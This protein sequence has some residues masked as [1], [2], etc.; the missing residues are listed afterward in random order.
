MDFLKLSDINKIDQIES[1]SYYSHNSFNNLVSFK[2]D[3]NGNGLLVYSRNNYNSFESIS[4]KD[5]TKNNYND[6][7]LAEIKDFKVLKETIKST[8]IKDEIQLVKKENNKYSVVGLPIDYY[9]GGEIT[10]PPYIDDN[11]NG[12]ATWY[13]TIKTLPFGR[14]KI[15]IRKVENYKF[16]G[17]KTEMMTIN[18]S[19]V[20]S[21]VD[22][23]GNGVIVFLDHEEDKPKET[24]LYFS[25]IKD[26]KQEDKIQLSDSTN[27]VNPVIGINTKGNGLIVWQDKTTVY[28]I[29]LKNYQLQ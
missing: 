23:Q 17:E 26:F 22:S 11:G 19:I 14:Y 9:Y 27:V 24:K 5:G 29:R 10:N 21:K 6:S 16:A 1:P 7:V 8:N 2:I 13:E 20:D 15:F 25:H 12:T 3:D 4:V 28:G 18:T